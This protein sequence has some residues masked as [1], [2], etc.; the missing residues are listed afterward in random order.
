MSHIRAITRSLGGGSHGVFICA[1]VSCIVAMY[2]DACHG[3]GIDAVN[4]TKL[5]MLACTSYDAVVLMMAVPAGLGG[6]STPAKRL[7]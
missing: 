3:C 1:V 5:E 6:H 4:D 7:F 2:I